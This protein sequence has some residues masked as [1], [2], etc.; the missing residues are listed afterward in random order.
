MESWHKNY[1]AWLEN[2][3]KHDLNNY[4][5]ENKLY[6]CTIVNTLKLEIVFNLEYILASILTMDITVS[7]K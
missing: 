2:N 7:Q 4:S 5:L 6:S 1:F 3:F